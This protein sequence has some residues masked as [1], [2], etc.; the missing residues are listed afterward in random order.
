MEKIN[1]KHKISTKKHYEKCT[2]I[3][4]DTIYINSDFLQIFY[5]K[6]FSWM[7]TIPHLF[8]TIK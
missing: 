2:T 6:C 1:F 3:D 4:Y 7:K 8:Y 5:F